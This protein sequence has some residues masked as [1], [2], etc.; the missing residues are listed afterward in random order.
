MLGRGRAHLNAKGNQWQSM[1]INGNQW[2][3][4]TIN[5]NQWFSMQRAI[6]FNQ[7]QSSAIKCKQRQP[8]ATS[9]CNAKGNQGHSR[10]TQGNE[11]L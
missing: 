2:Q 7:V 1:A 4:M 8:R 6:K 9:T 5:D 10:A 3:S 11:H